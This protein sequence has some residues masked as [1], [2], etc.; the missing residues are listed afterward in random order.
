MKIT[1]VGGVDFKNIYTEK[2]QDIDKQQKVASTDRLEISNVGKSLSGYSDD[3]EYGV[4]EVKLQ[5]IRNE[6]SSG[7]YNRASKLVAQK[8]IDHMKGREL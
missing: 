7:S 5:T 6:V 2:K 3:V 1:G 8:I 4:S